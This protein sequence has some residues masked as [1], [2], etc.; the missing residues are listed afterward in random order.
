M[1]VKGGAPT[2]T[3]S[4]MPRRLASAMCSVPRCRRDGRGRI[5]R[6]R[7]RNSVEPG[8]GQADSSDGGGARGGGAGCNQPMGPQMSIFEHYNIGLLSQFHS[9]VLA[10][11]SSTRARLLLV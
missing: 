1:K 5:T 2:V 8:Q 6:G 11:A 10:R 9:R 4:P 7:E 3:T